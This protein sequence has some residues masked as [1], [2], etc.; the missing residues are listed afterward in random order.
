M[1]GFEKQIE[2]YLRIPPHSFCERTSYLGKVGWSFLRRGGEGK[3]EEVEYKRKLLGVTAVEVGQLTM[4][5]D[6]KSV[7]GKP[8]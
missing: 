3:P 1:K 7:G 6:S 2:E 8:G 4:P 5:R